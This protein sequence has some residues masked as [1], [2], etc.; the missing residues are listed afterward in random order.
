MGERTVRSA[1]HAM[2]KPTTSNKAKPTRPMGFI[3]LPSELRQSILFQTYDKDLPL[4]PNDFVD[5]FY[6]RKKQLWRWIST[7]QLVHPSLVEDVAYVKKKW[8]LDYESQEVELK[9]KFR[10]LWDN[11]HDLWELDTEQ[12]VVKYFYADMKQFGAMICSRE[13]DQKHPVIG[14]WRLGKIMVAVEALASRIYRPPF[15]P[16][17]RYLAAAYEVLREIDHI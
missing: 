14:R 5:H 7:L 12:P 15:S 11:F 17:F 10:Y 1:K 16:E 8:T 3:E 2:P 9:E 4:H 13:W 6:K